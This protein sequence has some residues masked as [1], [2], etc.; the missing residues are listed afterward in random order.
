MSTV[1]ASL[2]TALPTKGCWGQRR[3]RIRSAPELYHQITRITAGGLAH[4]VLSLA[5]QGAAPPFVFEGWVLITR[6]AC[7][8]DHVALSPHSSVRTVNAQGIAEG[9]LTKDSVHSLG[10]TMKRRQ[11]HRSFGPPRTWA[12]RMT[13]WKARKLAP[14]PT[15]LRR[16]GPLP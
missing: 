6:S 11:L 8:S 14:S 2:D 9:L 16:N 5:N 10:T 12:F 7:Q 15:L 4:P 3:N 13:R 1:L